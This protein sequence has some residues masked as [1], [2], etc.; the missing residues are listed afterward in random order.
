M[1]PGETLVTR[2][3]DEGD[4]YVITAEA[5]ERG[6]TVLANASVTPKP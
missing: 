5:K 2:V 1:F 6:T 3:W 4:R